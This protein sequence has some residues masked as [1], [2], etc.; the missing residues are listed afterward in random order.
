MAATDSVIAV[1]NAHHE[2]VAAV[3]RLDQAG[4]PFESLSVVGKVDHVEEKPLGFYVAGDR[5]Q[6][7][8]KRGPLWGSLWSLFAG[9][10]SVTLPVTGQ[11]MVLGYL[12]PL[13]A[14]A[15]EG[16]IMAGGLSVLGAAL[17]SAGVSRDSITQY[18]QAVRADGF[19]VVV[20]TEAD[21]LVRAKALLL[22]DKPSRLD[23]HEG[24]AGTAGHSSPPSALRS[25]WPW[26]VSES[27]PP[28]ELSLMSKP[29]S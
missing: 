23:G 27:A 16:T 28:T 29:A 13:V 17:Y 10:A 6:F 14:S 26:V 22:L 9:G 25:Q 24:L 11:I 18:E 15:V 3:R 12:A 20:H 21:E 4:F 8:G 19:L 5:I 2:A 1:F 7:W